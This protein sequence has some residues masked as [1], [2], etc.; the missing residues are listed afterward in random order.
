MTVFLASVVEL[1]IRSFNV[2]AVNAIF[3]RRFKRYWVS[4]GSRKGL[5]S[6]EFSLILEIAAWLCSLAS[7]SDTCLFIIRS[8]VPSL[9]LSKSWL[10][11]SRPRTCTSCWAV[12]SLPVQQ[13]YVDL[14]LIPL[15]FPIYNYYTLKKVLQD[16]KIQLNYKIVNQFTAS[17]NILKYKTRND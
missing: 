15:K 10:R 1:N 7:V 13:N 17:S 12:C 8:W 6:K 3:S 4:W 5:V 9:G 16:F 2:G 11:G 14:T